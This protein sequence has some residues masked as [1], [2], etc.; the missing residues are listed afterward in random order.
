MKET[1]EKFLKDSSAKSKDLEHK[2]RLQHA[3]D[4]YHNKQ[5]K[6]LLQFSDLQLAKERAGGIRQ[7]SIENLEKYLIEFESN[8]I[9]NGGKLIWARDAE[10]ALIEIDKIIQKHAPEFIIKSKSMATEEIGL[11]EFLAEKKID[12][13]ETDLGEFVQQLAGEAPYHIVTPC[14]QKTKEEIKLLFEPIRKKNGETA[15]TEN[16]SAEELTNTARKYLRRYLQTAKIGITGANFLLADCGAIAITENEGNAFFCASATETHIAVVGIEK[17]IPSINDLELLWPLL[18]TFGTGQKITT[19]NHIIS[20]P[21]QA[22]ETEGPKEFYLVLIDNGRSE[23]LEKTEQRRAL[24][25]IRCGACYNVCPVYKNIGGHVYNHVYGGPIGKV[26]T[27]HLAKDKN[28]SHLSQASSLCGACTE[29]CPVGIDLHKLILFNRR[30]E[31]T[32]NKISTPIAIGA[33]KLIWLA[34][35]TAMLKRSNMDKGG[36]KAKNILLKLLFKKLWGK[37]RELPKVAEKSFNQLMR[38][39]RNIS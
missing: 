34:W 35:K 3:F 10:E 12:A 14:L 31:V 27:P 15:D 16:N 19:Y 8:F 29:I 39:Q 2:S 33:E 7:K 5:K 9:K 25:C 38:E 32:E 4:N 1:K 23:L 20:G 22:D 30:D 24:A 11:N 6:S 21:R 18:A 17:I 26:I 28:F 36:A 13:I 37:E